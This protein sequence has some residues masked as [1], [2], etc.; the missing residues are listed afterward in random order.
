M[1]NTELIF[2]NSEE[3]EA[4]EKVLATFKGKKINENIDYILRGYENIVDKLKNLG[5][6]IYLED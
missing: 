2:K 1:K 5:A 4:T 3:K 6:K